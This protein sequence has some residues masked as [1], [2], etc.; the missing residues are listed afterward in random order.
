MA[1]LGLVY[2]SVIQQWGGQQNVVTG[3][4][5]DLNK[6]VTQLKL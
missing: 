6:H 1:L 3:K 5:L 4:G 2:R